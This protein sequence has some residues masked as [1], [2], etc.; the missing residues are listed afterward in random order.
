M[1]Q[2]QQ[3]RL[4][5][6][7]FEVFDDRQRLEQCMT[8]M[9]EGRHH[10]FGIHCLIALIEL[11]ACEDIDRDFLKCQAFQLQCDSNPKR[12]DRTPEAVYLNTHRA[13]S[14]SSKQI[15]DPSTTRFRWRLSQHPTY[16]MPLPEQVL[17]G[18]HHRSRV[19]PAGR[20]ACADPVM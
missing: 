9:D 16:R 7:I 4:G 14:S 11:L 18:E 1:I 13:S 6:E 2:R 3:P 19:S 8:V 12:G 10:P 5:L 20:P 15:D 17:R